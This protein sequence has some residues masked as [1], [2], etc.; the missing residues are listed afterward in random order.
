MPRVINPAVPDTQIPDLS[1]GYAQNRAP[2]PGSPARGMAEVANGLQAMSSAV[3]RLGE[4]LDKKSQREQQFQLNKRLIEETNALNADYDERVTAAPLGAEGFTTQIMQDYGERFKSVLEEYEAQG[5]DKDL[6]NDFSLRLE[7]VRSDFGAKALG[8]QRQSKIDKATEDLD[9][10]SVSISQYV[11]ANPA[12]LESGL[13]ELREQIE[14]MPVEA[15]VKE[16]LFD[17]YREVIRRGAAQGLALREPELVVNLLDPQR[18]EIE[19]GVPIGNSQVFD[20]N[21]YLAKTRGAESGGNDAARAMTSSAEGR[22]QFLDSTWLQF[23]RKTFPNDTATDAEILA[24]RKNGETQE[25]VMRTFTETNIAGLQ[26]NGVPISA[27]SVYLAHF[28]GLGDAVKAYKFDPDTPIRTVVSIRSIAANPAVFDDI[29]NVGDLIRWAQSKMGDEGPIAQATDPIIRLV[30]DENFNPETHTTGNI[31]LDQM[32]GPERMQVLGWAK[33]ELNRRNIQIKAG[34]DVTHENIIN[35]FWTTGEFAG[36]IPPE[37]TYIQVYGEIAGKQKFAE[38]TAAQEGGKLVQDFKTM[39]NAEI[40]LRLQ[41]LEPSSTSPTYSR[42]LEG[43]Q[44]VQRA[45]KQVI[46]ARE[47]DPAAYVYSAFPN[48]S[49][50]MEEAE[51]PEQRKAA[52]AAMAKA[53]DQL[54]VPNN[55]RTA[56]SEEQMEA[57]GNQYRGAAP[58]QKLGIIKS[59]LDEMGPQLAG[60]TL[61][62]AVG[63]QAADDLALYAFIAR[64]GGD[65]LFIQVLQGKDII[66]GDPARKP[67]AGTINNTFREA[68]G[69]SINNLSPTMSRA[70]NEAAAAVYVYNGG[71]TEQGQPTDKALYESALRQV[72]GGDPDNSDTGWADMTGWFSKVDDITILPPKVTKQEFENWV[73]QL[74]PR[75]LTR[76]S[77]DQS[78]PIYSTGQEALIE[79]IIDKGVFVLVSPGEYGIKME[80]DGNYLGTASGKPFRVRVTPQIIR[81]RR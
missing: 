69:S 46:E 8:F 15:G 60:T 20:M 40:Q 72:L 24:K 66:K 76:L 1:L 28:L 29:D 2:Y 26:E 35:S 34:L 18:L 74:A 78:P 4:E 23:Y 62:R 49:Q 6:L 77:V 14:L 17:N 25:A 42:E 10:S 41:E 32:S 81:Q 36:Q 44:T 39:S 38:V 30:R 67:N 43:Y 9:A 51:T 45:A 52:Y 55:Q 61:G 73:D 21:S 59:W 47:R 7:S 68:V 75:D 12:T 80:D 16:K 31:V 63:S 71:F 37:E 11:T 33:E 53:Y 22:Y 27:S 19:G 50:M 54:G 5:F 56:F 13:N 58:E 3:F 70:V 65:R 48:I 57:L 79:D 64:G